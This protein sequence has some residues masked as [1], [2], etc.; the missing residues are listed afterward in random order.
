MPVNIWKA[1]LEFL[2]RALC[3]RVPYNQTIF[4]LSRHISVKM[5]MNLLPIHFKT[6]IA[7]IQPVIENTHT[8]GY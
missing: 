6:E 2:I 4:M 3:V 1:L 7:N 8:T 5:D